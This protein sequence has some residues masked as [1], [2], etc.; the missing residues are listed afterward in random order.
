MD[1]IIEG[2]SMINEGKPLFKSLKDAKHRRVRTDSVSLEECLEIIRKIIGHKY[3]WWSD[4]M[5]EFVDLYCAEMSGADRGKLKKVFN[6][7][8]KTEVIDK[9][10]ENLSI[11]G[12]GFGDDEDSSYALTLTIDE[13]IEKLEDGVVKL[14]NESEI[15]ELNILKYEA[16]DICYNLGRICGFMYDTYDDI[17]DCGDEEDAISEMDNVF[18]RIGDGVD[19]ILKVGFIASRC[20]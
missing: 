19:G 16:E 10:D 17:Y 15:D 20:L 14:K 12:V 13:Y 5:V 11:L 7:L 6:I 2:L 8:V 18:K 4:A 3:H 1:L 9:G